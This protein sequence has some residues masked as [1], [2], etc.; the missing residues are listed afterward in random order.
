MRD[1]KIIA[2]EAAVAA[3]IGEGR[4]HHGAG[5]LRQAEA[6][7]RGVLAA[8]PDCPDAVHLLGVIAHQNGDDGVAVEL[9][10]KA[11]AANP[12]VAEYH[13]NLGTALKQLGRLEDAV[14]AYEEALELRPESAAAHYNLGNT[15]RDQ[16]KPEDAVTAF[17]RAVELR[18]EYAEAHN[19]LGNVLRGMG[20]LENAVAAFRRALETKT[21]YAH[22]HNNLGNA[23]KDQGNLDDAMA[24]FRTALEL[25]PGFEEAHSNLLSCL[26]YHPSCDRQ[27]IFAEH[28]KWNAQHAVPLS[29]AAK[30]HNNAA[31]PERRIR[32][33]LVSHNFRRH[34]VGYLALSALEALDTEAVELYCYADII[35]GDDLTG[36]FREAAHGWRPTVGMSDEKVAALIGG[37]EIDILV[38][39][40][41]HGTGSRLLVFA[42]RP[43]P[44]QVKWVGCQNNTTGMDAIDYFISDSVETPAHHEPW[45]TE[46][47]VRL[48]D[49]YVCYEPPHYAPAVA[50]PP[51]LSNGHITFGCFNNLTKVNRQAIALW[52]RLLER[53][54]ASRLILKA[55]QL[56]DAA[57][58]GR[59]QAMFAEHG[60]APE[61]LDLLGYSLHAELLAHYHDVDIALDPFPYSGC[62]TTCEALWMGVPVVTMPGEIFAH[63]HS[64]S[65][66][67]TVGLTDWLAT[68]P[69]QYLRIAERH[70]GDLAGLAGLRAG[71]RER[72]RR[73]PLCDAP[74][75]A[76]NLEAAFRR[77]W[78]H[79]CATKSDGGHTPNR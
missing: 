44:V 12:R 49:S 29:P 74:R 39:M 32:L 70:C 48:P 30:L 20:Q 45:Y 76:G 68:T 59:Y 73:S 22:A 53:A 34:P 1:K 7:Y 56:N 55:K 24:A 19:N 47:V 13:N 2:D 63:R 46:A 62:L 61:R 58:R 14:A 23:F 77:M 42:H 27:T 3:A 75:F 36:R 21:D 6:I 67:G 51:A 65:F 72:V 71:L 5:R 18:P 43:A 66:L 4:A 38:D 10:T 25:N 37:D 79:W 78:R 11:I 28:R 60:I 69:E 64:A 40:S 54:P 17:L 8:E 52:S 15:L 50:P 9:I 35:Q 57:V 16:D 31:I 26:Y 33:G 41:G